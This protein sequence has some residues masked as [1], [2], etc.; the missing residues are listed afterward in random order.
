MHQSARLNAAAVLCAL[1]AAAP[2]FA[3]VSVSGQLALRGY[4]SGQFG[5]DNPSGIGQSNFLS[6]AMSSQGGSGS[7]STG[8]GVGRAALDMTLSNTGNETRLRAIGFAR[9][10]FNLST[11]GADQDEFTAIGTSDPLGQWSGLRLTISESVR[12]AITNRSE[13]FAFNQW[14][15]VDPSRLTALDQG[16]IAYDEGSTVSGVMTAGTYSLDFWIGAYGSSMDGVADS[17]RAGWP[18]PSFF[19]SVT[20]AHADWT[21]TMT[22]VPAPGAAA[23]L[24]MAC[25]PSRRRR[26]E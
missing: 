20:S 15:A 18:T 4:V 26:P 23:L 11:G 12:F 10:D 13:A 22:A 17:V 14:N 24:L 16:S 5:P 25:G 7:G 9:H 1:S 6:F 2:S 21:I 3:G 8:S 19:G